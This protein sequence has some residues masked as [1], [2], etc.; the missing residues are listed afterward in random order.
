MSIVSE[1]M[2]SADDRMHQQVRE[3]PVL[4]TDA[5]MMDKYM[6]PLEDL[7]VMATETFDWH[8]EDW[9]ALAKRSLSPSFDC[10]GYKW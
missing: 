3:T 9:R 8:I 10:G 4:I 6:V 2:L 1:K 5:S 7:E